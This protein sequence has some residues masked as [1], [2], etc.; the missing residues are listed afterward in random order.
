M[1]TPVVGQ[2]PE[3][4]PLILCS[5][6]TDLAGAFLAHGASLGG[7]SFKACF[8]LFSSKDAHFLEFLL[9]E[10]GALDVNEVDP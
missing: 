1:N 6:S 8:E 7:L 2:G 9:N 5:P 10:S 4:L 3:S